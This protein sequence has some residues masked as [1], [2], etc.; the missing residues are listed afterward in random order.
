VRTKGKMKVDGFL[1]A[2]LLVVA[3][4]AEGKAP[5]RDQIFQLQRVLDNGCREWVTRDGLL[6]PETLSAYQRCRS[7]M[8]IALHD[9]PGESGDIQAFVAELWLRKRAL[10]LLHRLGYLSGY[11]E[12]DDRKKIVR[13]LERI[14]T[15]KKITPRISLNT[16]D[17]GRLDS[18]YRRHPL[19]LSLTSSLRTYGLPDTNLEIYLQ[20]FK[21]EE[22]VHVFARRRN[23]GDPFLPLWVFPVMGS[24]FTYSPDGRGKDAGPKTVQGDGKVPEGC[25][26]LTWQNEWSDFYLGYLISYPHR[27]DRIRRDR[28]QPGRGTGGAIVLHGDAVTIGCIPVGDSGIEEIFLLLS[29]NGRTKQGYA[30]LHIFP[31]RFDVPEN[32]EILQHYGTL[33]PELVDFWDGLR[34]IYRYFEKY[35]CLP[36]IDV[37]RETGYYTTVLENELP[38]QQDNPDDAGKGFKSTPVARTDLAYMYSSVTL[39]DIAFSPPASA[40]SG[41]LIT[42]SAHL[43]LVAFD[44]AKSPPEDVTDRLAEDT[45]ALE[46][47][48]LYD[49]LIRSIVTLRVHR[50][51]ADE[52]EERVIQKVKD[53]VRMA[54][55]KDLF[56]KVF[57]IDENN[58]KEI[59]VQE[60]FF[61][62]FIIQKR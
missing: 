34:S 39:D 40:D 48:G 13:V 17:L 10:I 12:L 22:Q 23:S 29:R 5:T 25:Y 57:K 56:Q 32:E 43:G 3:Q 24:P 7:R 6:G 20:V 27:G 15:E 46:R 14:S 62:D 21:K 58:R 11:Y 42:F 30:T 52:F 61:S 26:R 18:W 50:K 37:G 44:H 55:N 31:C 59:Q 35:Q 36:D 49:N 2:I 41:F 38:R 54:L 47:I 60:V 53:E 51:T 1:F 9:A 4:S 16:A 33:R 28:W 45:D 19:P 8:D